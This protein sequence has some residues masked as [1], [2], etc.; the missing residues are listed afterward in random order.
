MIYCIQAELEKST[1]TKLF[2]SYPMA[3][4]SFAVGPGQRRGETIIQ[5]KY[6]YSLQIQREEPRGGTRKFGWADSAG[7][8]TICQRLINI[9]QR[10]R[11]IVGRIRWIRNQCDT[12]S[13]DVVVKR[14]KIDYYDNYF[15]QESFIERWMKIYPGVTRQRNG[16]ARL[17]EG[18]KLRIEIKL[19]LS[20]RNQLT[21]RVRRYL[22]LVNRVAW[23]DWTPKAGRNH[24]P[25]E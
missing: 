21:P 10:C 8:H 14:K 15:P 2:L 22:R 13:I 16:C 20:Q 4:W 7:T 1:S 18:S 3:I 6:F 25:A 9:I 24:V 5:F 17:V 12:I 23:S 19:N 11:W